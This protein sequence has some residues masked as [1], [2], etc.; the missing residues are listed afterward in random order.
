[1]IYVQITWSECCLDKF[2]GNTSFCVWLLVRMSG[3]RSHFWTFNRLLALTNY[4]RKLPHTKN[5]FF[6]F[7]QLNVILMAHRST[8]RRTTNCMSSINSIFL[9][10]IDKVPNCAFNYHVNHSKIQNYGKTVVVINFRNHLGANQSFQCFNINN[11]TICELVSNIYI[12]NLNND[13]YTRYMWLAQNSSMYIVYKREN[14]INQ[15]S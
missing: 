3:Y 14:T 4:F 12:I 9:I 7:A 2:T 15:N 10:M 13:V 11:V 8:E 1:M 6:F 5:D